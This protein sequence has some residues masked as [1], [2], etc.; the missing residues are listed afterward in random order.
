[1][2]HG[3]SDLW[4]VGAPV[5]QW[6]R[7]TTRWLMVGVAIVAL[8]CRFGS[9]VLWPPSPRTLLPSMTAMYL[10]WSAFDGLR[11]IIQARRHISLARSLLA[12]TAVALL[13]LAVVVVEVRRAHFRESAAY[14]AHQEWLHRESAAGRHGVSYACGEGC[15]APRAGCHWDERSTL[16]DPAKRNPSGQG[17]GTAEV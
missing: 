4:N 13:F 17:I 1:M 12:L 11:I 14:H 7:M 8:T 16:I 15:P 9:S 6:P 3:N 5:V 10:A 2:K